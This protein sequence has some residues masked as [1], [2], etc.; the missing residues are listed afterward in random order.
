MRRSSSRDGEL[1]KAFA[2]TIHSNWACENA[3]SACH[4][5]CEFSER[6]RWYRSTEYLGPKSA[7]A[8]GRDE[9]RLQDLPA[10]LTIPQAAEILGIECDWPTRPPA[11]AGY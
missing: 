5:L 1:T 10:A 4:V 7:H 6:A 9:M 8:V 3:S 2:C 11:A